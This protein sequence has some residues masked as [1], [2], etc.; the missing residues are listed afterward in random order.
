MYSKFGLGDTIVCIKQYETM[1]ENCHYRITGAGSRNFNYSKDMANDKFRYGFCVEDQYFASDK[2]NWWYLPYNERV[3]NY[4]LTLEEMN[5]HFIT[6]EEDYK[7][8]LRDQ[9][10]K[11]LLK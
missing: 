4:C 6:Q 9:K 10:L 11:R 7:A 5:Q 2:P 1:K 8:Y 3:R